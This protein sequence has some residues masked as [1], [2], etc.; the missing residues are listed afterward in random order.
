MKTPLFV[1][2]QSDDWKTAVGVL[3]SVIDLHLV[4]CAISP[5]F[6]GAVDWHAWMCLI[7]DYP[8]SPVLDLG[9]IFTDLVW[10]CAVLPD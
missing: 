1:I 5:C 10:S 2:D 4:R 3:P 7:L 8:A 9:W 6:H